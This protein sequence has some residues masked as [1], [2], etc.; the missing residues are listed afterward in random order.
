MSAKQRQDVSCL[1]RVAFRRG[2]I[3]A[4]TCFHSL[5]SVSLKDY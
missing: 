5:L 2:F 4:E 3:D 1:I